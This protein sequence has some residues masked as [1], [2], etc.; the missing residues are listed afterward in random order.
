MPFVAGAMPELERSRQTYQSSDGREWQLVQTVRGRWYVVYPNGVWHE[1]PQAYMEQRWY[2]DRHGDW[3]VLCERSMNVRMSLEFIAFELL[4]WWEEDVHYNYSREV[5]KGWSHSG[6]YELC[7]MN[8]LYYLVVRIALRMR[9]KRGLR[10]L[11]LIGSLNMESTGDILEG[12]L[13]LAYEHHPLLRC[14][15]PDDVKA[16]VK[17]A[18]RGV[19]MLWSQ[20][21][22]LR[23]ISEITD[24]LIDGIMY[25]D[26]LD[27]V[28]VDVSPTDNDRQLY[29]W[30]E[31]VVARRTAG[32]LGRLVLEEAKILPLCMLA[33]VYQFLYV[34]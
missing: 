24:V 17:G 22:C 31:C 26:W 10:R 2:Y 32:K 21:S 25:S 13:G 23:D 8:R 29:R 27:Q 14:R 28:I 18:T 6:E 19:K 11:H 3:H 5:R 20:L 1:V 4:E 34:F 12:V 30:R 16:I 33:I 7:E 15:R 9:D